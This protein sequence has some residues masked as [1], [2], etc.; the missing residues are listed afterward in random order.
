MRGHAPAPTIFSQGYPRPT[1]IHLLPAI[2]FR[3]G[4]VLTV[5]SV[6]LRSRIHGLEELGEGICKQP[7]SV[8]GQ[9]IG[10]FL[11]RNPQPSDLF[12]NLIS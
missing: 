1:G 6:R 4:P 8:I 3:P 11:H 10:D 5:V 7:N 2:G 9:F 12:H